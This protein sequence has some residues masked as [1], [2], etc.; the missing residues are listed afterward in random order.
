[1]KYELR[2][3]ARYSSDK[4]L[5]NDLSIIASR[6]N[7]RSISSEEYNNDG[8]YSVAT[9][10]NR[11]GSWNNALQK[12]GLE[13]VVQQNIPDIDLFGNLEIMW[14]ILGRQPKYSEV[15]KP[16]SKY[17]TRPY[18]N[19]FGGWRNACEKFIKYKEGD[20]EFVKL[21]KN[22]PKTRSRYINEKTRL[23]VLKRDNYKCVK[24]GRSPATNPGIYL[25]VDHIIPF[26]KDGDNSIENLQTLC[27]KCNLG[28]GND[29]TV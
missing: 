29:E 14:R 22:K 26:S 13:L 24:C 21:I 2:I 23:K 16:F 17:S 19:R 1:M 7:K 9:F 20:I 28:K 6:L 27:H 25:H 8:K 4:E 10:Q 5:L 3:D 18:D 11:F 12:A 15:R